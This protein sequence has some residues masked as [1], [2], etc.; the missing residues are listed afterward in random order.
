MLETFCENAKSFNSNM[1]KLMDDLNSSKSIIQ[2]TNDLIEE[3]KTDSTYL[4]SINNLKLK[5]NEL[6]VKKFFFLL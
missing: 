5:L 4:Y 2:R 6:E 3:T 1:T